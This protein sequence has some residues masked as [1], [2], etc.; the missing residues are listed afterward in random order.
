MDPSEVAEAWEIKGSICR[1]ESLPTQGISIVCLFEDRSFQTGNT[2]NHIHHHLTC[3]LVDHIDTVHKIPV[4][5]WTSAASMQ[6][7]LIQLLLPIP[8]AEATS[9]IN[10]GGDESTDLTTNNQ[11]AIKNM[12]STNLD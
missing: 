1:S 11:P 5:G 8:L 7:D 6:T 4:S 9:Q 2:F 3:P 10:D 12:F